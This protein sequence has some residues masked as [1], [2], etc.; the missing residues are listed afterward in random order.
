MNNDSDKQLIASYLSG[1]EKALEVLIQRYLKQIYGFIYNSVKNT[2]NAD[3]LTQEVFVKAWK[4]I[5]KFKTTKNFKSWLFTIA[6]NTVIDFS[7]KK[8]EIPFS[9]F[10]TEDGN[11]PIIDNL[12]DLELLPDKRAQKLDLKN[13]VALAMKNLSAKYTLI[14][15][16]Y[17]EKGLTFREISEMLGEP[18]NT[19]K[20]RH[21]RGL[22]MLK[23]MVPNS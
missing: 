13:E 8:K 1:N 15:S 21:R 23:T 18:L 4:N 6:K 19:I 14:L 3:D 7:R 10:E 9:S 22:D 17:Y 11:N 2:S 20:S 5:K 12:S 16:L